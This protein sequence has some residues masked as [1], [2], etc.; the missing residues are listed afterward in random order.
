MT[1]QAS[2]IAGATARLR[3]RSALI[4]SGLAAVIC[5]LAY[6][7][8]AFDVSGILAR[9]Q[10]EKAAIFAKDSVAHKVHVTKLM[11][12]DEIEITIENERTATF[13]TPPAWVALD[14]AD[15]VVDLGDGVIARIDGATVTVDSPERGRIVVT[16]ARSGLTIELPE[17]VFEEA[18]SHERALIAAEIEK[19]ERRTGKP[20]EA[21]EQAEIAAFY[22][23]RT[24]TPWL[25]AAEKRVDV[26]LDWDKR[27]QVTGSK[28]ELHRFF[29]GWENFWFDF[30][31]PLQGL[32][33]S[34]LW[35]LYWSEDRLDPSQSNAD[36]I[37]DGFMLNK[38]WRHGYVFRS[39]FET[40]LMAFLGTA[41]AAIFGL[42]LAFLAARN[43]TPSMLLRFGVR[44]VFDFLRGIDMLIWSLIFIRAFGLGPLTGALAIAFTDT[45]TLGK[46]FSE[47]LENVDK[48]QIEGVQATG[49]RQIQR[50]RFGVI[51]Q[52]LPVF[53]SQSLYFLES[54]T[55]SAT[56]IG[57]LGAGG[58]GLVLVETMNTQRDWENV[59]YLIIMTIL[60]VILMD[61][62]SSWLRRRLIDGPGATIR[63]VAKSAA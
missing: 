28:I 53:I 51:P 44:R 32:S 12:R 55:R 48:K 63:G 8:A 29:Y 40:I 42:P 24:V 9:A 46:L 39:L 14:G 17:A 41:L 34:E 57:A 13:Q 23:Q 50:Y 52:I 54:N 2:D 61:T 59:L 15:A 31:S 27:L 11:R 36:L 16:S 60:V 35:A 56:V 6:A 49:A 25:S 20:V 58:I 7:W 26:S 30:D 10:P 43:F 1:A 37:W 22:D 4:F 5:Y 21:G 47:A 19:R 33:N 45:G 38:E 18:K 3:L 62:L